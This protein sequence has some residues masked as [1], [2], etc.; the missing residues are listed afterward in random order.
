[1]QITDWISLALV[2][3]LGVMS[4]GPSVVVIFAVT[5]MNG[6][7]SGLLAALGHGIGIFLYAFAAATSLSFIILN[8]ADLF[9]FVQI[10]AAFILLWL[11]IRLLKAS[12]VNNAK[13]ST[14]TNDDHDKPVTK[15]MSSGL[16]GGFATGFMIA[17]FNPKIGVFF[18]TI[19][20]QFLDQDQSLSLHI[21]MAGLAGFIDSAAYMVYVLAFSSSLFGQWIDRTQYMIERLFGGVLIFLGISLIASYIL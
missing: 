2:C 10:I 3:L 17:V 5:R 13:P 6:R 8:Y 21:G 11:G 20:S 14:R 18:A 1:M 9:V 16:W 15:E 7:A 12:F 4:P 19:F